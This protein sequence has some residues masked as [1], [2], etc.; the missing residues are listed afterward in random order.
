[1][2][3][4][5]EKGWACRR[6]L[7]IMGLGCSLGLVHYGI[8]LGLGNLGSNL[9]PSVTFNAIIEV[10]SAF[11]LLFFVDKWNRISSILTLFLV[12]GISCSICAITGSKWAGV[13]TGFELLAFFCACSSV[14][15][16]LDSR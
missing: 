6:I 2:K 8:P 11:I 7:I 4:L 5:F 16:Y 14:I 1:M 3:K 9:Y 10:P 15:F 13:K 12:S